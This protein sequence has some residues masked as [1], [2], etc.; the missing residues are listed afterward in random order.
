M[1]F[2]CITGYGPKGYRGATLYQTKPRCSIE[3]SK[4]NGVDT[5]RGSDREHANSSNNC[6][7]WAKLF[8]ML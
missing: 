7:V 8:A 5:K 4:C 1:S 6:L 2:G 3:R